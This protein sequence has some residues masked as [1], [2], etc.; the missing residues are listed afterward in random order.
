MKNS[1][2]PQNAN[3]SNLQKAQ[4]CPPHRLADATRVRSKASEKVQYAAPYAQRMPQ[5][6]GA[7]SLARSQNS[8]NRTHIAKCPDELAGA[9]S[10]LRFQHALAMAH[11]AQAKLR[12]A[13]QPRGSTHPSSLT[14]SLTASPH[15][16][17][18]CKG[19]LHAIPPP[20]PGPGKGHC[21][22]HAP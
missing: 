3:Q 6:A 5:P 4:P 22:F 19:R 17:H 1:T 13:R 18:H 15:T 10:S 21:N 20:I 9:S 14:Y 8:T 16:V 2:S 7:Q 11:H 12:K